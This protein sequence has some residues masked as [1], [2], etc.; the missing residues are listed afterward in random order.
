VADTDGTG[1][2]RY[3]VDDVPAAIDDPSGKP[4]ELFQPR[5]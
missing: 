1:Y 2:V 5:E 4:V 3:T